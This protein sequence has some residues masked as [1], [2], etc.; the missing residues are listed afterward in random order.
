L[1]ARR[2]GF[3]L[4]TRPFFQL[5]EQLIAAQP[6][7]FR[8]QQRTHR[9]DAAVFKAGAGFILKTP[10]AGFEIAGV[11]DQRVCREV[12]EQRRQRL[13]E[14]QRLPVFDPGGSVPLL[15]C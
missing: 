2:S 14:K 5:A 7:L 4:H 10:G 6:Q 8:R 12:A 11:D 15:T 1:S 13:A 9:V 3:Q